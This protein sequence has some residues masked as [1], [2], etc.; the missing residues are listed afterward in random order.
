MIG[1]CR[2][3]GYVFRRFHLARVYISKD[4]I[5]QGYIFSKIL[6][7]KG[8]FLGVWGRERGGERRFVSFI[9]GKGAV[10]NFFPHNERIFR[11][12]LMIWVGLCD[13]NS[14]KGAN[15]FSGKGKVSVTPVAHP[16]PNF[17]GVHTPG[18]ICGACCANIH[19][20]QHYVPHLVFLN[21][22]KTTFLW[23]DFIRFFICYSPYQISMY[24]VEKPFLA[25]FLRFGYF[26]LY[27]DSTI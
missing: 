15:F 8:K 27:I 21:A 2:R 9:S 6:S 17:T 12:L 4:F 23:S 5:W 25:I 14:G 24:T 1:M 20:I 19:K 22:E 18:F 11:A 13:K 26:Y 16:Y 10:L 3:Q 7:G